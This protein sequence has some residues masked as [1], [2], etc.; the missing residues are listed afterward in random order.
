[1]ASSARETPA[2][3]TNRPI[4][5]R[6]LKNPPSPR[7][8]RAGADCEVDFFFMDEVWAERRVCPERQRAFQELFFILER[9]QT[10]FGNLSRSLLVRSAEVC[11]YFFEIFLDR[12]IQN[13]S[14][15]VEKL[16]VSGAQPSWLWGRRA[17]CLPDHGSQA[18]RPRAPQAGSLCPAACEVAYSIP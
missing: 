13:A 7:L 9:L 16:E 18:R 11:Q 2:R 4:K 15:T 14:S 6:R 3:A 8:R 12:A 5:T 17:S 1:V 10:G